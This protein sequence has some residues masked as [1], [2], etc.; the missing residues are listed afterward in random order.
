[1]KEHPILFSTPMVQANL[2]GRKTKTRRT[3]G[4][5]YVNESPDNFK[6]LEFE[7]DPK[8][9]VKL[10]VFKSYK[11]Y[12]AVF[13]N[14]N[15]EYTQLCKCPYGQPGDL[16]WVRETFCPTSFEYL[17]KDSQFPFAYKAD[18]KEP[19]PGYERKMM[20]EMGWK[21]KPSIHM[22][23]AAARIWLQVEESA[24]NGC[25]ILAKRMQLQKEYFHYS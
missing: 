18:L 3:R 8:I 6:F 1:M 21:W 2:A 15:E 14:E 24:W 23:K 10:E 12:F 22:P 7:T 13:F 17:H 25:R 11:G 4:L 16:L 19:Y 5:K 20:N 9:E